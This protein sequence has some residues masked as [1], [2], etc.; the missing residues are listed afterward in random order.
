MIAFFIIL[1]L[2]MLLVFYFDSTS[3]TIPNWLNLGV[4]ILY[5]VFVLASPEPVD[6]LGGISAFGAFFAVGFAIF[7]LGIMGGGDIKLLSASSL[8]VGWNAIAIKYIIYI[9]LIGGVLSLLL[10]V[11]R[12]LAFWITGRFFGSD[13]I[14]RVFMKG[15][16]VPYG[17]A[18]A[19][20]F[21]YLLWS[22]ELPNLAR[23]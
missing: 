23:V 19:G 12:P 21:L 5:P 18:I 9:A 15:E 4:L 20:I 2:L 3:Y 14:P 10:I 22:G 1:T 17:L 11:G 7:A 6:W 8:W 13:K 16:P